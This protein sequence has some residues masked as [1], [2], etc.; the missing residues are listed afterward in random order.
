MYWFLVSVRSESEQKLC[1]SGL[2]FAPGPEVDSLSAVQ[3]MR[4]N[5]RLEAALQWVREL[6]PRTL[7]L[8]SWCWD[9]DKQL[10]PSI[11]HYLINTNASSSLMGWGGPQPL[12]LLIG[13]RHFFHVNSMHCSA[14]IGTL[15]S[16]LAFWGIIPLFFTIF[17]YFPIPAADASSA[18]P[19]VGRIPHGSAH[20]FSMVVLTPG[21]PHSCWGNKKD[22]SL[23]VL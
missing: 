17:L 19:R 11:P 23:T 22:Q 8:P 13:R 2:R 10:L 18:L 16:V 21:L 3:S 9:S 6:N 14:P 5:P 1:F 15:R 7:Q 12:D 4:I 20:S